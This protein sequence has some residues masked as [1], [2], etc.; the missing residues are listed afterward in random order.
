MVMI[1]V[2]EYSPDMPD[3]NN[4]GSSNIRNCTPRT[5]QSYGPFPSLSTYGSALN[6]HCQGAYSCLDASDNVYVFAGDVNNLYKYTTPTRTI[7]SNGTNPYSAAAG[8]RWGFTLF[9]QRVIATDFESAIQSFLL[10]AST[11]TDLANGGITSLTLVGGSGYTNGTYALT[12]TGPGTGSGFAGTVTVSGGALSSF[13][14]TNVGKNY[15]QMA[16]I[17]IPG[18]AGAGTGGSITLTIA[19]IAPKA[20]YIAI[21]KGFLCAGNTND[22]VGGNQPQRV[23]WSSQNDPTNWPIPG[24]TNAAIFQSS[25][26]DLFGDGGWIK[27]IVGNLGNSDGAVFMEH[28]IWRMAYV[29]PP[30][31]FD[32]FPVE[33]ARGTSM[34][35]SI[36]QLGGIAYYVGEDGFYAYD[37]STS[38]PIG[39]DKVDKTFFADLDPNYYD[40]VTGTIDPI[41]KLYIVAYPGSGNIGGNPNHLM[42]Y[43]WPTQKWAIIDQQCETLFRGLSFSNDTLDGVGTV[44]LDTTSYNMFPM[45]SGVW[46]GGKLLLAGFDTSHK[47]SFFN[48][49]NLAATIETSETQPF[50]DQIAFVNDCRPIVDGSIPTVA[51]ATRNRLVDPPVYNVAT[52]MNQIGT[53]PQTINGRYLRAQVNIPANSSWTHFQGIEVNGVANGV[54]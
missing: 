22:S 14:I 39:F 52:S 13:I 23:W 34:P 12:V 30:V 46:V 25:Y 5:T 33:G 27:G 49:P 9:G 6:T 37:G 16:T 53:C 18:G 28:A 4:P 15:P 40:R 51:F 32:F 35:G 24:T 2:A 11:F 31:V 1:P 19:T 17:L 50:P 41:N 54:M 26:N 43:H 45:D 47:L 20:R 10:G 29:G 7:V 36:A 8:E 48:G 3:Y 44:S 38:V 21:V 42:V